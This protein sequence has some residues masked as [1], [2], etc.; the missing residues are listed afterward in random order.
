MN[1]QLAQVLSAAIH[2][3]EG[4]RLRYAMVGGLALA[5]RGVIRATRDVD[6]FVAIPDAAKSRLQAALEDGGFHVPALEEEL[7]SF[8]V[9]RSR[10]REAGLFLDIFNAVGELGDAILDHCSPVQVAKLSVQTARAEEI[11]LLK[12]FSDRPRDTDDLR[13]LLAASHGSLDLEYLRKWAS[14]LD[15]SLGSDEVSKRLADAIGTARAG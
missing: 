2:A 13:R 8:G 11:A 4:L 14:A 3:V 7:T 6:L 5:A 12:A 15:A 10:H 9:L 1:N